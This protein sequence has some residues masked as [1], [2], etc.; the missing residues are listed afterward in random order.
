M[1]YRSALSFGWDELEPERT[2]SQERTDLRRVP[3]QAARLRHHAGRS[4]ITL[5]D[6]QGTRPGSAHMRPLRAERIAWCVCRFP[7]TQIDL[8]G[9]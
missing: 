7:L 6:A 2:S 1:D 5:A 4:M 8:G 3:G 9:A